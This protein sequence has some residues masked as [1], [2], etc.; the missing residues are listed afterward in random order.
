M[1][2]LIKPGAKLLQVDGPSIETARLILRPW[3]VSDIARNTA[4][5]GDPEVARFITPDRTV[6][7]GGPDTALSQKY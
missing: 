5:L 4:M 7:L 1:V 2:S 3:R 6:P